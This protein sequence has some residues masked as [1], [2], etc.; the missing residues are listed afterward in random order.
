MGGLNISWAREH[1]DFMRGTCLSSYAVSGRAYSVSRGY[2]NHAR[3][4][5]SPG[6]GTQFTFR[7][8][9][10]Q[11][12]VHTPATVMTGIRLQAHGWATVPLHA[13]HRSSIMWP[14][15]LRR[16][17]RQCHHQCRT[18]GPTWRMEHRHTRRGRHAIGRE[19]QSCRQGT[20]PV[21]ESS[22]LCFMSLLL[23]RGPSS[24]VLL[25]G[26]GTPTI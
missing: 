22:E 8:C 15:T 2:V 18:A 16:S 7:H 5:H 20:R 24:Q 3:C 1:W 25:T 23:C 11:Y 9:R 21:G 12:F 19:A 17:C 4:T 14:P 26:C 6:D 13:C 10:S